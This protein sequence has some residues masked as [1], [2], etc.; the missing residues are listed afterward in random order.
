VVLGVVAI[1]L[2]GYFKSHV[3]SPAS[4][5]DEDLEESFIEL[6]KQILVTSAYEAESTYKRL[7]ARIEAILGRIL[8]RHRHFVL[9]VEA[10][11]DRLP[12]WN[13]FQDEQHHTSEGMQ[14]TTYAV[15]RDILRKQL[16]PEVLL[17]LCFFLYI[18]GTVKNVGQVNQ[19][20]G[21]MLQILDH[22]ITEKNY[23]PAL[24]LKGLVMKYGVKVYKPPQISE[25]Q[26]LLDTAAKNGV[27]AATIELQ[28]LHKFRELEGIKTVHAVP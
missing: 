13:L 15:R 12:T 14:Y 17:Y 18:G 27:G 8:E 7:Y 11:K 9:D 2:S 26:E 24:F 28:R 3:Q 10:A 25:A 21:L 23:M 19:D 22:L 20:A 16:S 5:R 6:K 1:L 4:L